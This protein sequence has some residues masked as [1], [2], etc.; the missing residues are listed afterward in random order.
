[1]A[2]TPTL[3]LAG[4]VLLGL[5]IGSFLNVVIHRLPRMLER[6]WADEEA[7]TAG[8]VPMATEPYDLAFPRSSC[9]HCGHPLA[10]WETLPVLS[11][12]LLRGRCL[13]CRGR[14]SA[15]YPLVELVTGALFAYAAWRW[16][17]S[18]AAAAWAGFGATLL[19][20]AAIDWDT[21]LLGGRR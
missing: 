7:A 19:A 14:I 1:M 15:R 10:A 5:L 18:P 21:T 11:W 2:S 4:A 16:G 17:L 6:R 13:A 12:L 3:V 9:P 8:R 20:L